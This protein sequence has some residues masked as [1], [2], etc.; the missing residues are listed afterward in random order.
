MSK[1]VFPYP[2]GKSRFASWILEYVPEHTTFVEVFAVRFRD[3]V[4]ENLGRPGGREQ[5][6]LAR[7]RVLS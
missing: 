6:R 4:L 2:G 3:V 5:V 7:D 1:A